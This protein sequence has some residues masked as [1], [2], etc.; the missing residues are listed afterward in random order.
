MCCRHFYFILWNSNAEP[1]LPPPPP[2]PSLRPSCLPCPPVLQVC[3]VK[4]RISV[5][6]YASGALRSVGAY[7]G[8][9]NSSSYYIKAKLSSDGSLL[10]SGSTND[11]V[12]LWQVDCPGAPIARLMVSRRYRV[13]CSVVYC[14]VV[15]RIM[16]EYK[17]VR[18]LSS[19][20]RK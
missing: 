8:N 7:T 17:L 20:R 14:T 18:D 12:C 2:P 13:Y 15:L 3:T 5:Y 1:S 16:P 4:N 11:A 10:A 6:A 19:R 9:E